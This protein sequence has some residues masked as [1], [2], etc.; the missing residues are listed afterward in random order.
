MQL[1]KKLKL[2]FSSQAQERG[3]NPAGPY[4]LFSKAWV[5]A[6]KEIKLLIY[7]YQHFNIFVIVNVLLIVMNNIYFLIVNINILE[8]LSNSTLNILEFLGRTI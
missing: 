2:F 8:T 6:T 7:T 1:K 3:P 5:C 4:M